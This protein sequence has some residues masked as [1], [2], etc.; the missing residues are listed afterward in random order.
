MLFLGNWL[1]LLLTNGL[2]VV[3]RFASKSMTNGK[4]FNFICCTRVKV[5]Q[6]NM[7]FRSQSS[8][9]FTSVIS[10]VGHFEFLLFR[11]DVTFP[12]NI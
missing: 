5:F 8:C 10:V 6:D 1:N 11:I 9:T 12:G 3:V 7:R 4:D 2:Q